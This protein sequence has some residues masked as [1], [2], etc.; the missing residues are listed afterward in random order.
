[1]IQTTRSREPEGQTLV[2]VALA[3][4]V[5]VGMVGVIIDVGF[6]WADNRGAQNGTDATAHAGAVVLMRHMSA[7]PAS[8]LD[9]GD[10]EAAVDAMAAEVGIDIESAE[11]TDYLGQTTIGVDVGDGGPIPPGAQGVYV[12]ASRTHETLLARV[13][14]IDELTATTDA[15]A[16]A[17]PNPDP[18][19]E[20]QECALLPITVPNTQVTCDGQNKAVPTELDWPLGEE[21]ILPL[22]GMFPEG[23]DGS[24]GR[25]PEA[26]LVTSLRTRSAIRIPKSCSPT[27]SS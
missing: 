6:Q 11:Y 5:L 7:G 18:C 8:L 4:V 3:M 21:L 25:R 2:I 10:V 22:C 26:V 1:M 13:V 17:G 12:V 23:S 20:G 24:I 27:G 19:S 9:D 15:A 14:G 16:V